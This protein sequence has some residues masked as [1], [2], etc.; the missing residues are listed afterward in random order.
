MNF[1]LNASAGCDIKKI[2]TE[3][4]RIDHRAWPTAFFFY[5]RN[6]VTPRIV[7]RPVWTPMRDPEEDPIGVNFVSRSKRP[8]TAKAEK[9]KVEQAR[10][11]ARISSHSR[12]VITGPSVST[13]ANLR[14][15][16]RRLV[17][18]NRSL[19][20]IVIDY[21]G[22]MLPDTERQRETLGSSARYRAAA[23]GCCGR[24][25]IWPHWY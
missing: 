7:L 1:A 25:S 11:A 18:E 19:R 2:E 9:E 3:D 12:F 20:F 17:R 23:Q 10:P 14:A 4:G 15:D 6:A 16:C 5:D 13:R 21:Q 24:S 8:A 22:L